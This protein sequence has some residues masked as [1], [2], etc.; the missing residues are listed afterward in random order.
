MTISLEQ[1]PRL[2]SGGLM[3]RLVD[4]WNRF[5]F[6]PADPLPLG[7]IRICCGL[8][9]LYIHIG[10]A[11]QLQPLFGEHAWID[12]ATANEFRKETPALG[13]T[14]GWEEEDEALDLPD[15]PAE[16]AAVLEYERRWGVDPRQA[17]IRGQ[18]VWSI[19]YHV[20]DP[21][22]MAVAHGLFLGI[23]VLFTLGVYARITSVLA[24]LGALSYINRGSVTYGVDVMMNLTLFYLMIGPSG[25]AL[26]IDRWVSRW[27]AFR[28]ARAR[29]QAVP[30]E[31]PVERL[32]T[33][34]FAVRLMQVHLCI[35]YL[36]S[37]LAKFR[38][39]AW[40]DGTALWL[41]LATYE[42]SLMRFEFYEDALRWLTQHRWLWETVMTAGTWFALVV[43]LSF[44]FAVWYRRGRWPVL[45][46]ALLLHLG[47]GLLMGLMTFSL[48]Y[49]TLL[50][51]F[52]PAESLR[53]A[54]D[55]VASLPERLR[56]TL[57]RSA[58]E[59]RA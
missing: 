35:I 3:Q 54:I 18:Y 24:W 16:R 58:S 44:P 34:N 33:A 6:A 51:S 59:G 12:L 29:G 1:S 50:L 28:K 2:P 41:I 39:A 5:W 53:T 26:S 42:F 23:L 25:A 14:N 20:T 37:A 17:V 43:E 38:G 31:A 22:W 10:Y 15:D 45:T 27:R 47:I 30:E 36:V 13:T 19:W 8:I 32:A 9:A 56:R 57:T 52:V 40:W 21:K 4:G 7:L 46:A 55:A 11:F 48:M 49:L